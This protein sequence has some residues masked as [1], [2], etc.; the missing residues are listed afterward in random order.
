MN[1]LLAVKSRATERYVLNELDEENRRAFEE[2]YFSCHDC[3]TD[4]KAASGFVDNA[5]A[6]LEDTPK[7]R[8]LPL[9]RFR[10]LAAPV[11]VAACLTVGY[12]LP[13]P[14]QHTGG[15]IV[16]FAVPAGARGG[17]QTSARTIEVDKEAA[18]YLVR[19]DV[20]DDVT[21]PRLLW[22]VR[23]AGGQVLR[24]RTARENQV[25]LPLPAA[26]FPVGRYEVTLSS[27]APGAAII[28][29]FG[30]AI[31]PK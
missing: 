19:L 5:K 13:H 23:T 21:A 8:R 24:F 18:Y 25:S 10:G 29:R 31:Q 7:T 20:A 2:H 15:M 30:F 27:D 4:V 3:A 28:E 1:H 16:A 12:F 9:A 14:S 6:V 17:L 11:A 26:E 22:R